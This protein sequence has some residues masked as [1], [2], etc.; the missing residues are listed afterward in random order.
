MANEPIPRLRTDLEVQHGDDGTVDV[1]DPHLLQVFTLPAED[2]ELARAF[3]GKRTAAEL[4]AQLKTDN[5]RATRRQIQRVAE[6]LQG[7]FLLDTA[8]AWQQEPV[9][10]NTAPE[11]QVSPTHRKLRVL[12]IAQSDARWSC[13]ACGSCCHGLAVEITPEEESRIDPNLY[14]DI[15]GDRHF[16]LDAFIDPE[17]KAV[18]VLR[19]R[20]EQNEAC[21]FLMPDG[22]CAVHARQGME[23]KP[24]ACQIFPH[25]VLQIP[26][27]KPRLALRLNC[28]TMHETFEAGPQIQGAVHDAMRVLETSPSH[29]LPKTTRYFGK[30]RTFA[31]V[32]A[33]LDRL[34]ALLYEGGLH[35]ENLDRIDRLLFRGRVG[36]ARQR[37]GERM[38]SY[39]EE[40]EQ[41]PVPLEGGGYGQQ[42]RRLRR[43]KEAFMAIR[44]GRPL[45]RLPVRIEKFFLGQIRNALYGCGPWNL[46]DAG[47]ATVALMLSLEAMMHAVGPKGRLKTANTAFIVMSGPILEMTAHAWPVLEAIDPRHARWLRSR[48]EV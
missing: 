28:E 48:K 41:T 34:Y 13:H 11:P 2:F 21:V 33:K 5:R 39:L 31:E 18:R 44:D 6:E 15:L 17:E 20:P 36:R 40:E 10:E 27:Q 7:I 37:Y 19:Q 16:A 9:V 14:R 43:G 35:V 45:P 47:Y 24:D 4:H 1:R 30:E 32:D 25:V 3:D 38:L 23:A 26:G 22:L 12:P 8:E 42:V 46:P 29:L